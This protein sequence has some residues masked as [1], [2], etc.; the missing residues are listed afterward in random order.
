M[1]ANDEASKFFRGNIEA[2][3]DILSMSLESYPVVDECWYQSLTGDLDIP[4]SNFR[5]I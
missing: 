1:V 4:A 3:K 2:S 5:G